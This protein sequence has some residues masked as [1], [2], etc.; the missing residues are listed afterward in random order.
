MADLPVRHSVDSMLAAYSRLYGR[1]ASVLAADFWAF[2]HAMHVRTAFRKRAIDQESVAYAL[3]DS[4]SAM[5]HYMAIV[6]R[7]FGNEKQPGGKE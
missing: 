4:A 3:D 5:D 7:E 1:S 6:Q 2:A